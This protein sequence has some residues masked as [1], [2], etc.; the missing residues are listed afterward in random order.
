MAYDASPRG[1][2]KAA[3]EGLPGK[4]KRSFWEGANIYVIILG[5]QGSELSD[6]RK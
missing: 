4:V 2:L 6:S 5:G 3:W 1:T